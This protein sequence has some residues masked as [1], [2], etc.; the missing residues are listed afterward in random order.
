ME[1]KKPE[2]EKSWLEVI[3]DEFQKDY[4]QLLKQFLIEEKKH[5][6]IYPPGKEIFNAFWST[7]FYKTK[8]I[9]LG[10]DPYHGEHQAHGLSF[11]VKK[12]TPPP[13]SL[14]NI[15]KEIQNDLGIPIPSHG[16]L[17][18][19]AK[20]GVLLLNTVL[21][22]RKNQAYSHANHGWEVFTDKVI[23]V[24]NEKRENLVFILWG[25]PAQAKSSMIDSHKHCVL[26]APHPSP[27]SAHRG[28]F[29][30]SHFSKTNEFLSKYYDTKIDWNIM[31]VSN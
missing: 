10:Q 21:T 24:L 18:Y 3:G 4:M 22:V 31:N 14:Q 29:G 8:V 5:F 13:P 16:D 1:A 19:L 6:I 25:K 17:S 12:G 7:P 30:C 26:K 2:I 11:S 23:E 20:Q 28:F 9:I 27:L 15:F